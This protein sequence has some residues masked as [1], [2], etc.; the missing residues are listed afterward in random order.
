MTRRPERLFCVARLHSAGLCA[1]G[2]PADDVARP[3]VVA[4]RARVER[5]DHGRTNT[6]VRFFEDGPS[7]PRRQPWITP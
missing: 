5:G 6:G 1:H 4:D 2:A 7:R 3:S